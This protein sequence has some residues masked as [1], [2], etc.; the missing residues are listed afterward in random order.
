[1]LF[2]IT[3]G[4]L[5]IPRSKQERSIV[6][7]KPAGAS[8][9]ISL[10]IERPHQNRG[11]LVVRHPVEPLYHARLPT[12]MVRDRRFGKH[13]QVSMFHHTVVHHAERLVHN[14]IE[15]VLAPLGALLNTGL[16]QGNRRILVLIRPPERLRLGP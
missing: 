12:D 14:R 1:M 2:H 7:V 4:E 10:V 6:D 9:R 15:T 16:H 13:D 8:P 11:I 3:V 5:V